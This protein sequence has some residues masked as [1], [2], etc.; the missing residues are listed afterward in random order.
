MDIPEIE[1]YDHINKI[2]RII[3]AW[4][5][6]AADAATPSFHEALGT[7]H[8]QVMA[9]SGHASF[10]TPPNDL[11]DQSTRQLS[12]RSSFADV[13]G[14]MQSNDAMPPWAF[15]RSS[16]D[17]ENLG[18]YGVLPNAAVKNVYKIPDG[19]T[20]Y[21]FNFQTNQILIAGRLIQALDLKV[22]QQRLVRT[23]LQKSKS[24]SEI[25]Q[26]VKMQKTKYRTKYFLLNELLIVEQCQ[27]SFVMQHCRSHV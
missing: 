2:R 13:S 10:A 4:M 15:I 16:P 5:A 8:T 3:T 19:A 11:D 14:A 24:T 7:V 12:Q 6:H 1:L 26:C 23:A 9:S 17:Q 18:R 20:P 27:S 21:E 22:V 25:K